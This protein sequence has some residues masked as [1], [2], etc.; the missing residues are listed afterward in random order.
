[1]H[2]FIIKWEATNSYCKLLLVDWLTEPSKSSTIIL[3]PSLWSHDGSCDPLSV[4]HDFTDW[5]NISSSLISLSSDLTSPFVSGCTI[6]LSDSCG[7]LIT[8]LCVGLLL[9]SGTSLL[10]LEVRP[11]FSLGEVFSDCEVSSGIGTF[12]KIKNKQ[13]VCKG[14]GHIRI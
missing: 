6:L 10:V 11:L 7:L 12:S 8:T 1:M 14:D 3:P 2:T 5:D 13:H 4:S 9:L